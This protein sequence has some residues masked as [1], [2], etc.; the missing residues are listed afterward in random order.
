MYDIAILKMKHRALKIP[1]VNRGL[2]MHT[3]NH[4]KP[5]E[6]DAKS[7]EDSTKPSEDDPKSSK[8]DR[9]TSEE[10]PFRAKTLAVH[11]G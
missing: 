9:K 7:S 1:K 3:R 6:D 5:F 2:L 11:T 8:D 4:R 10:D